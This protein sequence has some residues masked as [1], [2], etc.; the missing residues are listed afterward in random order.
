MKHF[1]RVLTD[2]L[3]QDI[4]MEV[5]ETHNEEAWKGSFAWPSELT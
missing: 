4:R 3:L 2:K 5:S 1:D